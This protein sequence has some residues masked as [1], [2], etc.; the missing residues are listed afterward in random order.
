MEYEGHQQ[1]G[2]RRDHQPCSFE[3][4]YFKFP[5]D[6]QKK[7]YPFWDGTLR[8]ATPAKYVGEG[9][10]KGMKVYKYKQTIAADQDRHDRRARA[11]RRFG[12]GDRHG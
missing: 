7:T 6:A 9:K 12:R 10:V 2:R 3:G 4:L 5:F 11:T 8:K 1:R